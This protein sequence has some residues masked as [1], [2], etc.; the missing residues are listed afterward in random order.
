MKNNKKQNFQDRSH[1]SAGWHSPTRSLGPADTGDF[2]KKIPT[3]TCALRDSSIEQVYN[4]ST[5]YLKSA[6]DSWIDIYHSPKISPGP[7]D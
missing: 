3:A 4:P 1:R 6:V 5:F 2:M 7:T